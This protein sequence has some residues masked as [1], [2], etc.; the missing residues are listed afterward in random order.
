VIKTSNTLVMSQILVADQSNAVLLNQRFDSRTDQNIKF[1]L[2]FVERRMRVKLRIACGQSGN[3][4]RH[5]VLVHAGVLQQAEDGGSV[6][7]PVSGGEKPRSRRQ[8]GE[9]ERVN[10]AI[11]KMPRRQAQVQPE[12][13]TRQPEM[14]DPP[15][16]RVFHQDREDGR[17]QMKMQVAVDVVESQAACVK[18]CELRFNFTFELRAQ[19]FA[20]EISKPGRDRAVAETSPVIDQPGDFL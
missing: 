11:K 17:V 16:P 5:V 9:D 4:F 8:P 14:R 12:A 10:R 1:V 15:V 19:A 13:I 3:E 2:K 7:D 18:L 20:K 6:F